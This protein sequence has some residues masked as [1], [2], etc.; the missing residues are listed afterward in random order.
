MNLLTNPWALL[1]QSAANVC[2]FRATDGGYF[3]GSLPELSD[4]PILFTA[5]DAGYFRKFVVP[6]VASWRHHSPGH[7]FHVHIYAPEP[8]D[9]AALDA[10]AAGGNF[11]WS[12]G[13]AAAY[14]G[15]G[16]VFRYAADRFYTARR[17]LDR[18]SAGVIFMDADSLIR[19]DISKSELNSAGDVAL[20]LHKRF[21]KS[22]S[23]SIKAGVIFFAAT[24][25]GRSY[26]DD[27]CSNLALRSKIPLFR[28]IDQRALFQAHI[29]HVAKC[30]T[31][32]RPLPFSMIDWEFGQ[33]A[34]IWTAKGAR[35]SDERFAAAQIAETNLEKIGEPGGDRTL[36]HMI[37]SHVLYR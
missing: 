1:L 7:P 6:L 12:S 33:D 9:R 37:K 35:K 24:A 23:L 20:Y 14:A 29:Y 3:A 22:P 32:F 16:R 19:G 11:T 13:S 2:R 17:L 31:D 34:T 36:D 18:T 10:V 25:G 26:L 30:R 4:L 27:V 15:R 8:E 21:Q 5:C 28:H